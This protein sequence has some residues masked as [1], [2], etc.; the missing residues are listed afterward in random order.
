MLSGAE[1]LVR[2]LHSNNVPICLATSSSRE[3]FVIKTSQHRKLF[4]L[5]HHRVMGS[6]EIKKG[7]PAPDI[8]LA[9]AQRF[10]DNPKPE[11]VRLTELI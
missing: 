1:R 5:F 2:H 11:S 10:P 9:T 7:K 4:N 6:S 3:S 8:F